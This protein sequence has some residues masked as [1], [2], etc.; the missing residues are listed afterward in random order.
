MNILFLLTYYH[1]HLSGLTVAAR[2]R[3]EGLAER[4]HRVSVVCSRH[5]KELPEEEEVRGVRVIRLPV[6][7]RAGKGVWMRGYTRRVL[8]EAGVADVLVQCLPVSPPEAVSAAVAARRSAKPLILDYACDLRLP[9]GWKARGVEAAV[10]QGHLVAGRAARAIVVSTQSYA[11]ASP[12]LTRFRD[13]L[14]VIPLT[15]L[16]PPPDP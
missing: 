10:F 2:N 5:K 9:R 4:G 6:A 12:F 13:L 3:A 15:M 1:P 8:R 7:W 16:I 14:R 11:E